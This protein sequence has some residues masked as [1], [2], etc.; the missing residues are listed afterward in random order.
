MCA[1]AKSGLIWERLPIALDRLFVP[2][3]A[4]E[5][6]AQIVVRLAVIGPQDNGLPIAVYRLFIGFEI[7]QGVAES[8]MRFGRTRILQ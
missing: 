5:G 4:G 8:E 3:E 2:F 6:D 1:A 7:G